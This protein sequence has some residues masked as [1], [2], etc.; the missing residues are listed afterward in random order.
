MSP[1]QIQ[2]QDVSGSKAVII[3]KAQPREVYA[4]LEGILPK[5]ISLLCL[6]GYFCDA[7]QIE[8]KYENSLRNS[9][10]L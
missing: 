10:P 8:R 7:S 4:I 3:R 2:D 6:T 5:L 1:F 9:N